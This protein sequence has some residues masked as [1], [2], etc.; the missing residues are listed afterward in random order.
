MR[1]SGT[2]WGT[3]PVVEQECHELSD[4]KPPMMSQPSMVRRAENWPCREGCHYF[5]LPSQTRCAPITPR[6]LLH[7]P[8]ADARVRRVSQRT[9]L[10]T[11]KPGTKDSGVEKSCPLQSRQEKTAPAP[12]QRRASRRRRA[13][14]IH[15]RVI[16]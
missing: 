12:H 16:T 7:S 4:L 11:T 10:C 9:G 15:P 5:S 3:S 14:T 6:V 13:L 1:E 8:Q 2:R